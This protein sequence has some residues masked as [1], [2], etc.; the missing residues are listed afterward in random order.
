MTD[1]LRGGASDTVS[2]VTKSCEPDKPAPPKLV[3]RNKTSLS[4]RWNAPYDN[5]KS[6][7]HYILESDEGRLHTQQV[8]NQCN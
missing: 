4:L 6:I 5:G 7:L 2:F 3:S 1:N 8:S